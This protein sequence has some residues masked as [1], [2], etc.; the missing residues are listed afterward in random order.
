M[1]KKGRIIAVAAGVLVAGG[2][3]AGVTLYLRG[4]S[5]ISDAALAPIVKHNDT[6]R[7]A[8]NRSRKANRPL[9][10]L[11]FD[12]LYE[13]IPVEDREHKPA[14]E[15]ADMILAMAPAPPSHP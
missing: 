12:R 10:A 5:A 8:M 7:L 6:L 3:A 2:L 9:S 11:Q 1:G 4:R 13:K 14:T 15:L